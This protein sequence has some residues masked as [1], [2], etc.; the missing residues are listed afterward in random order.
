MRVF[1]VCVVGSLD[2]FCL[3]VDQHVFLW[4]PHGCCEMSKRVFIKMVLLRSRSRRWMIIHFFT[5]YRD[6]VSPVQVTV[7]VLGKAITYER[8]DRQTVP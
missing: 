1:H 2:F 7:N 8:S 4:C 6:F 5:I 3:L